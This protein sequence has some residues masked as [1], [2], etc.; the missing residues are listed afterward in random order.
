MFGDLTVTSD[1]RTDVL[2]L[3]KTLFSLRCWSERS[4]NILAKACDGQDQS[5]F[6]HCQAGGHPELGLRGQGV[7]DHLLGEH[8][9]GQEEGDEDGGGEGEVGP[10]PLGGGSHE[11]RVVDAEEQ[12]Q[13]EEGQQATVE[14]LTRP[15]IEPGL[16]FCMVGE[17]IYFYVF[18]ISW[19][20]KK[21]K[22]SKSCFSILCFNFDLILPHLCLCKNIEH[23][24]KK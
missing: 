3:K 10:A 23:L 12:A 16:S 13:R 18:L 19:I 6:G 7:A 9:V 5:H 8:I 11:D 1:E 20:K 14:Y 2:R 17:L 15:G 21:F 22:G 4:E 24:N